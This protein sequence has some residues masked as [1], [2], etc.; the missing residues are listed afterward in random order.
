MMALHV[1]TKTVTKKLKDG[2]IKRYKYYQLVRTYRQGGKVRTQFVR[3]LG[4]APRISWSKAEEGGI[5]P[6]ELSRVKDL[7]VLAEEEGDGNTVGGGSGAE[8]ER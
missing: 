1:T 8:V 4:K 5:S 6:E 3:Y 2:S 7:E